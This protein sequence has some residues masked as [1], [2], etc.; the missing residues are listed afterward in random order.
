MKRTHTTIP[1][2][3]LT[4]LI[5]LAEKVVKMCGQ[6]PTLAALNSITADDIQRVKNLIKE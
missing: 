3:Q 5:A 6:S 1:T 2:T 4:H